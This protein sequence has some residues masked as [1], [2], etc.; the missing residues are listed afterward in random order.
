M[1]KNFI[2]INLN[3]FSKI[4]RFVQ[5]AQSFYSDIDIVKGNVCLDGK[6]LLGVMALDL[7]ENV[8]VRIISDDV[9][10]NRRFDAVMEEFR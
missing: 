4:K 9:A 1:N 10:E 7:S 3:D 6:S 2:K 8:Y 5:I